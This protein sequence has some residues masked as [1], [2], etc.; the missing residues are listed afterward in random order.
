METKTNASCRSH[1]K[2]PIRY[3]RNLRPSAAEHFL[4]SFYHHE[5]RPSFCLYI[6]Y[7]NQPYALL[8]EVW[9]ILGLW[10]VFVLSRSLPNGLSPICYI[11]VSSINGTLIVPLPFALYREI[12][13]NRY[14]LRGGCGLFFFRI[15]INIHLFD[16]RFVT[17]KLYV[18]LFLNR[19]FN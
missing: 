16:Y 18:L 13:S 8:D 19:Y 11:C 1:H 14:W 15:L 17:I 6:C 2:F 3:Y 5:N 4:T 12:V 9:L 7:T 10:L